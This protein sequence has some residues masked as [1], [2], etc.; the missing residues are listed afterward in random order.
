MPRKGRGAPRSAGTLLTFSRISSDAFM[1]DSI[2]HTL[3]NSPHLIGTATVLLLLLVAHE[4]DRQM[5]LRDTDILSGEEH[6]IAHR[7]IS[8]PNLDP[9]DCREPGRCAVVLVS[10]LNPLVRIRSPRPLFTKRLAGQ[11]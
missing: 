2:R 5:R 10:R 7:A 4:A 9:L 1:I 3:A 8:F 6:G 11:G